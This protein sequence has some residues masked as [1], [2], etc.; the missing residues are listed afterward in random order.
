VSRQTLYRYFPSMD[1][2]LDA[3]AEDELRTF[4]AGVAKAVRDHP[5]GAR[6]DA[7]L[8]FMSAARSDDHVSAQLLAAYFA[9][10]QCG[11]AR[12]AAA[13]GSGGSVATAQRAH[14]LLVVFRGLGRD[15]LGH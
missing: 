2:L 8:Q 9:A 10:I 14:D 1:D 11:R 3:V 5:P 6:L 13:F 12:G 7:V 15:E 4:D